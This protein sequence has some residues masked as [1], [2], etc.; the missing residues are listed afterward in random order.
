MFGAGIRQKIGLNGARE[1]L[2]TYG[3]EAARG[4]TGLEIMMS[5]SLRKCWNAAV[6]ESILT[7]LVSVD[8]GNCKLYFVALRLWDASACDEEGFEEIDESESEL[9]KFTRPFQNITT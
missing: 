5:F 1:Q 7:D 3:S 8:G 9:Q 6:A 4:A 2:E